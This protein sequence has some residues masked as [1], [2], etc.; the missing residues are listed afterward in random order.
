MSLLRFYL[1]LVSIFL[2]LSSVYWWN[3]VVLKFLNVINLDISERHK[4]ERQV[5]KTSTRG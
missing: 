2:R 5:R 4:G 3:C 1:Q